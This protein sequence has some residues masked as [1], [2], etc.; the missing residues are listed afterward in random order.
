M[1]SPSTFAHSPRS[2]PLSAQEIERKLGSRD[3]VEEDNQSDLQ[4]KSSRKVRLFAPL[5]R[6][7]LT[8]PPRSSPFPSRP[9][10]AASPTAPSPTLPLPLD[11]TLNRSPF[12]RFQKHPTA[13][14]QGP[15]PTP[16]PLG[17]D[18][19]LVHR[20][21]RSAPSTETSI[22]SNSAPKILA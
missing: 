16:P 14:L 11:S 10:P 5:F 4:R 9:T 20:L 15:T 13:T 18:T 21:D 8:C 1:S 2:L 12:L 22:V 6:T 7:A 19:V 3:A 17:M